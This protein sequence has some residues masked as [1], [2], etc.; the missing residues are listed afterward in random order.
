LI[1]TGGGYAILQAPNVTSSLAASGVCPGP[2][3]NKDHHL[4][5]FRVTWNTMDSASFD[6]GGFLEF[7]YT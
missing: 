6:G 3:W 7:L 2:R 5:E 4:K 1:T